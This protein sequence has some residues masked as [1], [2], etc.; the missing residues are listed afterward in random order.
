MSLHYLVQYDFQKTGGNLKSLDS[1]AKHLRC[2]GLLYY[3]FITQFAG[4]FLI[5][6]HLVKYTEQR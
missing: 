3:K 2:D 4:I 6:E 1:T 5:S